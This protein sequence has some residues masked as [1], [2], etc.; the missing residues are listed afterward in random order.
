MKYLLTAV[1]AIFALGV[2]LS[3]PEVLAQSPL[4]NLEAV[5]NELSGGGGTQDLTTTIA[6][7]INF[8]L[9]LLG[10]IALIL[11]IYAGFLWMFAGGDSTKVDKAKSLLLN[12]VIGLAIILAAYSITT[13]VFEALGEA[14]GVNLN[15][16]N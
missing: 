14:T 8:V 4:G 1:A 6:N 9:G 11:V 7:V 15:S 2:F 16:A 3:A 12:A 5:G 10:I 13:F